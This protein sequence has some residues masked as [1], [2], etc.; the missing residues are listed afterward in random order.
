MYSNHTF[1]MEISLWIHDFSFS[2]NNVYSHCYRLD[3]SPQNSYVED[4][5]TQSGGNWRWNL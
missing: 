5:N 3:V 1:E 4:L 2:K